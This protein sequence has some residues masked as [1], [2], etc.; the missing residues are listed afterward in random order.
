MSPQTLS[1]E[2]NGAH[3]H[4]LNDG[5]A[6]APAVLFWNGAQ[7]TAH[8]WDWVVERLRDRYRLVRFDIRG[9]GQSSPAKNDDQYS[10]EQY[11]DDANKIL[12]V[13]G[14]ERCIIWSMAW[15][16]RA[17]LAYTALNPDRVTRA[18]FFDLSIGKADVKAQAEGRREALKKQDATGRARTPVPE[19]WNTHVNPESVASALGAAQYFDLTAAVPKLDLPVLIATGDHDPN[20]ASS[21]EAVR[22]APNAQ[23]TIME[24]VGHGSILQRPDLAVEIFEEFAAQQSRRP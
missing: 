22:L 13:L 14:V 11:A 18:A 7:C 8:M 3:L 6:S 20:L 9:T 4:A 5:P 16:S 12:D 23:L 2:N 24:N 15:G 21:R 19:G 17:A 10:L 1:V